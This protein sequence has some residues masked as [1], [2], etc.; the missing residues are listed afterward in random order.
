[1]AERV[2]SPVCRPSAGFAWPPVALP[3]ICLEQSCSYGTTVAKACVGKRAPAQASGRN[4]SEQER[5]PS[6]FRQFL[7][8]FLNVSPVEIGMSVGSAAASFIILA[9]AVALQRPRNSGHVDGLTPAASRNQQKTRS[10]G[11]KVSDAKVQTHGPPA[12]TVHARRGLT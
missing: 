2:V 6:E 11:A 3:V 1:M 7:P 5:T 8:M 9:R 12:A 10:D 4:G